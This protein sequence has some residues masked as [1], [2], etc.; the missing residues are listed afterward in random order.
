MAVGMAPEGWWVVCRAGG[1]PGSWAGVEWPLL[2]GRS[3]VHLYLR[4]FESP[5]FLTPG[6]VTLREGL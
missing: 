1:A 5:E 4:P 6:D 3:N 2:A